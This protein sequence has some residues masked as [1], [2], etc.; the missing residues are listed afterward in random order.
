MQDI[1]APITAQSPILPSELR[2]KTTLLFNL[3]YCDLKIRIEMRLLPMCF[4]A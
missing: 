3:G 2:P 4:G 1:V